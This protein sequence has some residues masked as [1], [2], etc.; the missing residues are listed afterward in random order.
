MNVNAAEFK[1]KC[2]KLLDEVTATHQPL[3][4]TERGRPAARVV[5]IDD[6]TARSGGYTLVA[7]DRNSRLRQDRARERAGCLRRGQPGMD[8]VR[9][10]NMTKIYGIWSCCR[11]LASHAE[12]SPLGRGLG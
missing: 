11:A 7:R 5:P 10:R 12:K 9:S 4:I 8:H 2:R 1:A 3:V 6:A